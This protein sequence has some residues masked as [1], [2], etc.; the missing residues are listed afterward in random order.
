MYNLPE[1]P[2]AAGSLKNPAVR[3]L[4]ENDVNIGIRQI[5][6]VRRIM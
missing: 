2:A 5:L 3:E 4:E 1:T 6:F